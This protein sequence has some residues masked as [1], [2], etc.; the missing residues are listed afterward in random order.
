M[1]KWTFHVKSGTWRRVSFDYFCCAT[2]NICAWVKCSLIL[3]HFAGGFLFFYT[4]HSLKIINMIFL[5]NSI[6]WIY[7]ISHFSFA[8]LFATAMSFKWKKI[9]VSNKSILSADKSHSDDILVCAIK[10]GDR[11]SCLLKESVV[12]FYFFD[13]KTLH[14]LSHSFLSDRWDPFS[15]YDCFCMFEKR[16]FVKFYDRGTQIFSHS[17]AIKLI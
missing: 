7:K 6:W 3:W 12:K 11:S 8:L 5:M 16:N 14:F 2:L 10:S 17:R 15:G 13:H 9:S 4:F 1:F